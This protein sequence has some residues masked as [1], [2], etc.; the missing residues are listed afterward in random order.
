MDAEVPGGPLA[1]R[2]LVGL[3]LA[4]NGSLRAEPWKKVQRRS[5]ID[6][7]FAIGYDNVAFAYVYLNRCQTPRHC[8]IKLRNERSK[9]VQFSLL[10]YF[11]AFLRGDKAA[12]GTEVTHRQAKLQAQ[13]WFEH[14]EALTLAYRGRLKEADRLSDRAVSLARQ[15][16][17][18]ER[19]AM[20]QGARAVWNALFGTRAE[21][22]R[23]AATALSLYRSRDADY[24]PAFALALLQD[25][26]RKR[27][28]IAADL[29]RTLP[30]GYVCPVQLSACPAGARCAQPG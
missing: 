9:L 13:G 18:V 28:E 27:S 26:T 22:Q 3:H 23:S 30:A 10:R 29:A 17:L 14:Q 1:A 4:R 25:V 2:I 16:G 19:A 20:F 11:I 6:P 5:D 21:A 24:G 8:C 15:G 7:D 12:M